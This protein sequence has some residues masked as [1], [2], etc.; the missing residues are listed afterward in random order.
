ML[1]GKNIFIVEDN[2]MNRT[3][4]TI[5]LTKA[6]CR[7][8][9]DRWGR[10]VIKKLSKEE[11]DIV[12]LDLMLPHGDSGYTIHEK[13]RKLPQYEKVPIVAVSASEPTI[14]IPKVQEL[15]FDGFIAKPLDKELFP[16]QLEQLLQGQK[17]WFSGNRF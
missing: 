11:F 6:G 16:Q 14:T 12:I 15:G 17:I 1:K 13:I 9:F 10:Q 3:V 4:Y 2:A 7:V 5:I 8:S